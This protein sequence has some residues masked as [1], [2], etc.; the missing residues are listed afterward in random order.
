MNEVINFAKNRRD[1]H[2]TVTTPAF[3]SDQGD[4]LRNRY[5]QHFIA[6]FGELKSKLVQTEIMLAEDEPYDTP[7]TRKTPKQIKQRL[8][9]LE[10]ILRDLEHALAKRKERDTNLTEEERKSLVE[11]EASLRWK[12]AMIDRLNESVD[13]RIKQLSDNPDKK[14][15]TP[16]AP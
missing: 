12:Q 8:R 1:I 2:L 7:E 3:P 15:E 6:Q 14:E 9:D 5:E 16:N 4:M 13:K 11:V 10:Y